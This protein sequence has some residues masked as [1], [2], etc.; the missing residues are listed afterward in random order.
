MIN[1][2]ISGSTQKAAVLCS[3][4]LLNAFG[5]KTTPARE[6]TRGGARGGC[7][8]EHG[9]ETNMNKWQQAVEGGDRAQM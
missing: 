4:P 9:H 8:L 3:R 5:K 7:I 1:I 6:G 2:I